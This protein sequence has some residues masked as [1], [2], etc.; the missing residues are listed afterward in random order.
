M[1]RAIANRSA[2][3]A[4][5][6]GCGEEVEMV[7][8]EHAAEIAGVTLRTIYRWIDAGNIH[9]VENRGQVLVCFPALSSYAASLDASGSAKQSQR[10]KP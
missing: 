4:R 9:F 6:T 1:L 5:C 7:T 10:S 2:Y 3:T 8:P